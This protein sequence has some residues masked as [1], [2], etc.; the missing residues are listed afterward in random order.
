[1]FQKS[2]KLDTVYYFLAKTLE[3]AMLFSYF[4]EPQ[5]WLPRGP[6]R[7]AM[8]KKQENAMVLNTF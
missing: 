3:D 6:R 4:L 1:M 2:R 8:T 5:S 7:T